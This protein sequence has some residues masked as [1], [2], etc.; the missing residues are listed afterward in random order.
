MYS[1]VVDIVDPSLD[2]K[3]SAVRFV[4]TLSQNTTVIDTCTL[5][6]NLSTIQTFN[7]SENEDNFDTVGE[8]E[9]GGNQLCFSIFPYNASHSFND[10]Y[11]ILNQLSSL[12]I[13]FF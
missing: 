10:K 11:H 9:N 4:S 12:Q 6:V 2:C 1:Y 5:C 8:G 13:H 7:E 3:L